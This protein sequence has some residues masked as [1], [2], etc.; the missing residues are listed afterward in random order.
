MYPSTHVITSLILAVILYPWFGLYSIAIFLVGFLMDIDHYFEYVVRTR[1]LSPVRACKEYY[2][3][4]KR[5]R[6]LKKAIK[7]DML[8][9]F[10]TVE[11]L[12]VI[13]ILSVYSKLFLAVLVTMLSIALLTQQICYIE[14]F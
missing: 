6:K 7:V 4:A 5:A 13:A 1:D 9:V 12:V 11:F 3:C 14:T 2:E 10:H 8:H